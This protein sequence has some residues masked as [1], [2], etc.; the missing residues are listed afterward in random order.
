MIKESFIFSINLSL[1]IILVLNMGVYKHYDKEIEIKINKK[2]NRTEQHYRFQ[3]MQKIQIQKLDSG[4]KA[5]HCILQ[6]E[7]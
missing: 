6:A 3:Q 7:Y 4:L 5:V 2:I 1:V